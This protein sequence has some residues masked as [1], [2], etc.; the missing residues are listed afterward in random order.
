MRK[1]NFNIITSFIFL[2][3]ATL[4]F[5]NKIYWHFLII[6]ASATLSVLYHFAKQK[7]FKESDKIL[8]IALMVSNLYL[9]Y[10]SGFIFVYTI[11]VMLFIAFGFYFLHKARISKYPLNHPIWHL[12]S[13]MITI[14][15]I[16]A[17]SKI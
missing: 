8:A 2:I 13:I 3:P 17:Y 14:L 10:L 15:C 5:Y 16:L 11:L 4:S 9:L 12:C 7:K 1:Y 6:L